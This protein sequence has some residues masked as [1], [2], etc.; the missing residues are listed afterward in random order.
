M[1]TVTVLLLVCLALVFLDA[2][3]W[4]QFCT[5]RY[6]RGEHRLILYSYRGRALGISN[7][8]SPR[9]LHRRRNRALR[10]RRIG[11]VEIFYANE[12]D[13]LLEADLLAL[14]DEMAA[15]QCREGRA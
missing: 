2:V 6:G 5:A 4:H 15:S 3:M 8:T 1:G 7:S 14:L 13:Q 10:S 11:G 9:R 12:H